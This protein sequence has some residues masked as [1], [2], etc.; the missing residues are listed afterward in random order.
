[1]T[2][3][4]A[5]AK[6]EQLL[7]AVSAGQ[8]VFTKSAQ[9]VW[10]IIGPAADIFTGAA[11]VV[12]KADGTTRDVVVTAVTTTNEKRGVT[13][14]VATFRNSLAPSAQQAAPQRRTEALA[15]DAQIDAILRLRAQRE[16]NGDGG[17]FM[18]V[19]G[20]V[21]RESLATWT[22]AAAS[23]YITSLSEDY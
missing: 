18:T 20:K 14:A 19:T 15:T 2:D 5:T 22:R 23:S 21:T 3:T 1:M 17:G 7:A 9:G 6:A 8:T 4:A 10:H 12:T 11:V 16:R 13:Y